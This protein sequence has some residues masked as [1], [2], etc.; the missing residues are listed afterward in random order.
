MQTTSVEAYHSAKSSGL[1]RGLRLLVFET[2]YS[3]G[4]MT[5]GECLNFLKS[6]GK[7]N[8]GAINT[9]FSELLK[10][11]VIEKTAIRNCKVTGFKAFEWALTGNY[12]VK[13]EPKEKNKD[14]IA[15]L[16]KEIEQLKA[17]LS[18]KSFEQ[19]FLFTS[20]P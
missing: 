18:K 3:Q 2:L 15:R 8:S 9:R 17:K 14:K 5:Q 11:G 1:L 6:E 16:E 12:P 13:L 19:G 7:N 20:R 10:M 4:A